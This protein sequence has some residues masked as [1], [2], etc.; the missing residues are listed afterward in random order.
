MGGG[1]LFRR[2]ETK[3]K[4][5]TLG[6]GPVLCPKLGEDQ[7]KGLRPEWDRALLPNFLQV[8]SQSSHIL[9]ANANGRGGG[10]FLL[11]VQKS[12]SKVLKTEH[13]AYSRF[14]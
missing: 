1:G 11:L 9:I 10:L 4:Q 7:K 3:L 6:I 12:V 5:L 2:C 8:L 14:Q 13:F